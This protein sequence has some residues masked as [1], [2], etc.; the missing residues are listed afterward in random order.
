MVRHLL[1]VATG[2]RV[3]GLLLVLVSIAA[4]VAPSAAA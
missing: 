3:A 4:I 2:F 1:I